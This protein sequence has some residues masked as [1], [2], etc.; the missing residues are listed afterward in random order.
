M[1]KI[2]KGGYNSSLTYIYLR[3]ELNMAIFKKTIC[4]LVLAAVMVCFVF[5]FKNDFNGYEIIMNNKVVGY[6]KN[7]EDFEKIRNDYYGKL[8]SNYCGYKYN[9]EVYTTKQRISKS[10]FQSKEV[11]ENNMN[12]CT[13][14]LVEAVVINNGGQ[15]AAITSSTG[16]FKDIAYDISKRYIDEKGYK[17]ISN[18]SQCVLHGNITYN[19]KFVSPNDI[20]SLKGAENKLLNSISNKA[21]LYVSCK[22]NQQTD[23][24]VQFAKKTE[25]SDSLEVS[26]TVTKQNGQDGINHALREIVIDNNNVAQNKIVRQ[27]VYKKPI[28]EIVQQGTKKI[29]KLSTNTET[30]VEG[31]AAVSVPVKGVISSFFGMR[32]GKMHE[33]LDIAANMGDPIYAYDKATV[34]FAG[35]ETGYGN[36]VILRHNNTLETCYGHCS[37][38]AVKQGDTVDKGQLIAYV[39][40]T[41]NSTGP[42]VHF[43]VRVNGTAQ[44]PMKYLK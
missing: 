20:D 44:D 32:W 26:K 31:A 27:T 33:G 7:I 2:L 4:T 11:I 43:E 41:G 40:S 29:V 34:E 18:L 9:D 36:F 35:W 28:D 6:T 38:L 39:G 23:E 14:S 30:K 5:E 25:Y 22:F 12:N 13:K 19:Y 24:K 21:P 10:C 42:H 8:N 1:I 3:K 15:M 17:N 16:K 37:K